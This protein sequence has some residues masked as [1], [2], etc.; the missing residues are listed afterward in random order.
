MG[1]ISTNNRFWQDRP[2]FVTGAT[3]LVG[4][5]LVRQLLDLNADVVCLVRD[6]VPQCEFVR[7]QLIERVRVVRGDVCDQS[8]LERALGEYEI[9]S[10]MIKLFD[11]WVEGDQTSISV[12][13]FR[14]SDTTYSGA[15][16][17]YSDTGL[18]AHKDV[19]ILEPTSTDQLYIRYLVISV[20]GTYGTQIYN[21]LVNAV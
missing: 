7:G 11:N 18:S 2:T 16:V 15:V 19:L 10:V 8:L 4:G 3:G 21:V 17:L 13:G 5:W 14:D 1:V 6:W 12:T 20:S 9:D